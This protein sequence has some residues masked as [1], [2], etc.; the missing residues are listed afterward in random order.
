MS[1]MHEC[2]ITQGSNQRVSWVFWTKQ[3]WYIYSQLTSLSQTHG[4]EDSYE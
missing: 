2:Q 1:G 3:I 4:S